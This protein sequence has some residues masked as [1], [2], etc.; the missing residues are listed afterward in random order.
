MA[1]LDAF[2]ALFLLF[3]VVSTF[4]FCYINFRCQRWTEH[5]KEVEEERRQ[6]KNQL[7]ITREKLR[8]QAEEIKDLTSQVK[9]LKS[10]KRRYRTNRTALN[11]GELLDDFDEDASVSISVASHR[12]WDKKSQATARALFSD[13]DLHRIA[14]SISQN[15]ESPREYQRKTP[16]KGDPHNQR[17]T[18]KV[19]LWKGWIS[20]KGREI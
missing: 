8:L 6:I 5:E 2:I 12:S 1:A 4:L 14:R 7:D 18:P 20:K 19:P 13:P 3:T 15:R 16:T 11:G 10:G 17:K 9:S